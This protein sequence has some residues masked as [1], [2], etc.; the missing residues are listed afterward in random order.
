L[1][2]DNSTLGEFVTIQ[3]KEI[4]KK[5]SDKML[6]FE[7]NTRKLEQFKSKLEELGESL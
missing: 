6:N 3:K 7:E 5:E 1:N 2:D 4:G